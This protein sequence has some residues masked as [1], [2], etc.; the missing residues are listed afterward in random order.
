MNNM[1]LVK[2]FED[3]NPGLVILLKAMIDRGF[4]FIRNQRLGE[5]IWRETVNCR[6]TSEQ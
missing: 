3:E 4:E 1:K 2:P 6:F 5:N